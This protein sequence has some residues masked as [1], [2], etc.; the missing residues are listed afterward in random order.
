MWSLLKLL[1]SF[2]LIC[3]AG[4]AAHFSIRDGQFAGIGGAAIFLFLAA[5]P[6]IT[7]HPRSRSFALAAV[8]FSLGVAGGSV[9]RYGGSIAFPQQ[10]ASRG[11]TFCQLENGLYALG[12]RE[13]LLAVSACFAIALLLASVYGAIKYRSHPLSSDPGNL[14]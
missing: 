9:L 1:L 7:L 4:M 11:W 2:L 14:S 5:L 3:L 8:V 12:G 10:C 6:W 13:L